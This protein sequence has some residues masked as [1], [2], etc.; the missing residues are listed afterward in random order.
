MESQLLRGEQEISNHGQYKN[1]RI[2]MMAV[3]KTTL[4]SVAMTLV[5]GVHSLTPAIAQDAPSL[6]LSRSP[7]EIIKMFDS[8]GDKRISQ[9]EVR[10]KNIEV[11]D[12]IDANRDSFLTASELPSL[13]AA[14][15]K[16]ADKDK[17]GKL[18]VFEYSQAEFLRFKGIDSN[19]DG[20]VTSQE[21]S[22]FQSREKSR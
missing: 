8:N 7:M 17:D 11:F 15:L 6:Q 13:S 21:I 3:R 19:N 5:W 18:S 16:A 2:S 10:E 9:S 4:A 22:A 12:R 20:F 1:G 14:T